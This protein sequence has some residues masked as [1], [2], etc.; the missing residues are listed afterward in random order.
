MNQESLES[1][2]S[3]CVTLQIGRVCGIL[4]LTTVYVCFITIIII[5]PVLI[6]FYPRKRGWPDLPHSA[7]NLS[8]SHSP[9]PSRSILCILLLQTN[10]LTHSYSSTCLQIQAVRHLPP[11]NWFPL[12]SSV[13]A[14]GGIY[15]SIF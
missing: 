5:N 6:W 3:Q 11:F 8:H 12:L 15:H 1:S 4:F 10:T 2:L 13:T 14:F 7:S 9:S